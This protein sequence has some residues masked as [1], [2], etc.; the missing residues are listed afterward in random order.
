M[1]TSITRRDYLMRE[2]AKE[3]FKQ[4]AITSWKTYQKTGRHLTGQEIQGW[5]NAWG[6]SKE[7][8]APPPCHD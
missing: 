2:E 8:D 6:T 7:T 5:L 4:E 3:S 1:T